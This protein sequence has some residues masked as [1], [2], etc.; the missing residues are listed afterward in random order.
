[1]EGEG[2]Y[3]ISAVEGERESKRAR[4]G[5]ERYVCTGISKCISEKGSIYKN[6]N[7]G[8]YCVE[9]KG[10]RFEMIGD[11]TRRGWG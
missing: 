6:R 4:W 11:E 7:D 8:G 10:N 2:W 9:D 1:V 3:T 5:R